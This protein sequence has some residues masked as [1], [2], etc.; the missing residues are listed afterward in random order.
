MRISRIARYDSD[1]TPTARLEP[2]QDTLALHHFDEGGGEVAKNSSANANHGKFVGARWVEVGTEVNPLLGLIAGP[3]PLPDGRRWQM[4][5]VM[6]SQG[7]RSRRLVVAP[8]GARM[9]PRSWRALAPG[10]ESGIRR[11][12]F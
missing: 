3:K 12:R 8:P 11:A 9:A 6:D 2:D 10:W 1:F 4:Q 5:T 7:Q